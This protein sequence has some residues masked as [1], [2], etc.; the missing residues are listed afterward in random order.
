MSGADLLG[1]VKWFDSGRLVLIFRR[2]VDAQR[3]LGIH[4][5]IR[6]IASALLRFPVWKSDSSCLHSTCLGRRQESVCS[7]HTRFI[8]FVLVG[9]ADRNDGGLFLAHKAILRF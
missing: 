8:R 6:T 1:V 9:H 3:I 7:K 5:L 4:Q 2:F